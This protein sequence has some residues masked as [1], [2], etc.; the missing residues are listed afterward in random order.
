MPSK[1]T[2]MKI[3]QLQ[4]TEKCWKIYAHPDGFD[5]MQCQLVLAFGDPTLVSDTSVFNHLERNYPE[6]YIIISSTA[7]NTMHD[8]AFSNSVVV[9]AVQFDDMI[10]HCVETHLNQHKN[11]QEASR[12]LQ[13]QL[14]QRDLNTAFII[15]EGHGIVSGLNQ[16][17][18]EGVMVAVGFYSRRLHRKNSL[19]NN[20]PLFATITL[21]DLSQ[22]VTMQFAQAS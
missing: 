22:M 20:N 1:H 3:Q 2:L 9:T 11:C 10:I 5:R 17:P 13:Q 7:N 15:G 19:V 18:I 4:Y 21:P 16:L 14:Q 8:E 6:A 12:H